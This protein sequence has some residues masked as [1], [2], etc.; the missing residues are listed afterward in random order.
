M[1]APLFKFKQKKEKNKKQPVSRVD[2]N[3]GGVPQRKT[4][5]L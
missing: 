1:R 2:K 5:E 4:D 3:P